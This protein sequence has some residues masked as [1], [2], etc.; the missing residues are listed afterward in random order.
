MTLTEWLQLASAY[1]IPAILILQI[2]SLFTRTNR[3][4]N[5]GICDE[6][7]KQY[8]DIYE[9]LMNENASF[10]NACCPFSNHRTHPKCP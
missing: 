3:N 1:F 8:P 6:I 10:R 9:K 5:E 7:K 2:Y 4:A